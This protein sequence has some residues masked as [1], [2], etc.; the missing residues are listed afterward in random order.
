MGG[1]QKER[2]YT[3]E[4]SAFLACARPT[5]TKRAPRILIPSPQHRRKSRQENLT[6]THC[7]AGLALLRGTA[8]CCTVALAPGATA[9]HP[10]S[11]VPEAA[12]ASLS[13]GLGQ[14]PW[15]PDTA[16][17]TPQAEQGSPGLPLC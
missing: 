14:P 17:G 16:G 15:V 10:R 9:L 7:K 12:L 6:E 4:C 1:A 11:K 2:T 3:G 5:G 8:E 13:T